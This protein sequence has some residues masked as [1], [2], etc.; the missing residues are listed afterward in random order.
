MAKKT[1]LNIKLNTNSF[2]KKA[3][4]LIEEGLKDITTDLLNMSSQSA[5]ID[6][7]ILETKHDEKYWKEGTVFKSEVSYSVNEGD[8]NYAYWV[9]E[10]HP[11]G[12]ISEKTKNKPPGTSAISR[13]SFPAGGQFLKAPMDLNRK[14]YIDYIEKHLKDGL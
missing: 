10:T 4:D 11:I 9:H 8:F 13:K 2:T 3:E 1:K 14:A 5:P 12:G 6:E 7:K